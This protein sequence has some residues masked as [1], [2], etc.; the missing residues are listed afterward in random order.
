VQLKQNIVPKEMRERLND[1]APAELRL[2][3]QRKLR[4]AKSGKNRT[5]RVAAISSIYMAVD[6][7]AAAQKFFLLYR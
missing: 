2:N 4:R 6:S 3:L 1:P 5:G 7:E